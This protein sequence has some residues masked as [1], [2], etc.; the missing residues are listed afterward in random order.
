MGGSQVSRKVMF[1]F[2]PKEY[3]FPKEENK[4]KQ[5]NA[6]QDLKDQGRE[7]QGDEPSRNES[8]GNEQEECCCSGAPASDEGARCCSKGRMEG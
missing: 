7:V 8:E 3:D 4:E 1:F 6:V 2:V 5:E